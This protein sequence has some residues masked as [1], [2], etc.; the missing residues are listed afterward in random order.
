MS[1]LMRSSKRR[2]SPGRR[3]K[4]PD[5]EKACE[6]ARGPSAVPGQTSPSLTG[7]SLP[8]WSRSARTERESELVEPRPPSPC[9]R[10]G[11]GPYRGSTADPGDERVWLRHQD[12]TGVNQPYGSVSTALTS[13]A[14]MPLHPAGIVGMPWFCPGVQRRFGADVSIM[15]TDTLQSLGAVLCPTIEP[16]HVAD[17][18]RAR[19]LASQSRPTART[20]RASGA[21]ARRSGVLHRGRGF[22]Q[23]A[24]PTASSSRPSGSG[25]PGRGRRPNALP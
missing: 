6:F 18:G 12:R 25:S 10:A 13:T 9:T 20:A 21:M 4:H 2:G 7:S 3:P 8:W 24:R 19:L 14:P 1:L 17:V 15:D 22:V 11:T 5:D 23:C 16:P